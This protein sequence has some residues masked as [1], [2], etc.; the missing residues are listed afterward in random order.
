GAVGIE[1][2]CCESD[3]SRPHRK[4]HGGLERAITATQQDRDII[5]G[6]IRHRQVNIAIV[7][8]IAGDNRICPSA[9]R[10]TKRWLEG[11]IPVAREYIHR[12]N[13]REAHCQIED[14][15]LVEVSDPRAPRVA[16]ESVEGLLVE[17]AI[18]DAQ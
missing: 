14:A 11:T 4:I 8:E 12:T 3:W 15:V 5:V 6:I 7:V 10:E 13:C 9:G 17:G 2:S 16:T 1:I 18:S